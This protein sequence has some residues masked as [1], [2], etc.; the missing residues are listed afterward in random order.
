MGKHV[1]IITFLCINA[2]GNLVFS[3][4]IT[5][6]DGSPIVTKYCYEDVPFTISGNPGGGNFS[7]CGMMQQNGQWLFNPVIAAQGVSIF[8]HQ[9]S[10]NYTVNNQTVSQS[11]LIYKPVQIYPPMNDTTTCD[12]NFRIIARTLYAGAYDYQWSPAGPLDRADTSVATGTVQLTTTFILTATDQTSGC[13]G[14]DTVTIIKSLNPQVFVTPENVAI[15]ARQQIQLHASGAEHYYWRP[16]KYLDN[17]SIASPLASPQSPITYTVVGYNQYGCSDS[18]EVSI[19]INDNLFLPNAFSPNGDGINDYFRIE[20]F[21][22]QGVEAFYVF[23]RWGEKIYQ[24]MDGMKGWDGSVRDRQADA[25]IYYY[26]VRIAMPDGNSKA[27]K[28]ELLLIR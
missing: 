15:K 11:L 17:D 18:A 2:I 9:C 3:Q 19:S 23:N 24:T 21:G 25:G 7:G 1:L 5:N 14:S 8:P 27:F 6:G 28:G 16:S 10:I 22:Y 12:G 20:N 26:Y 13:Q 4:T